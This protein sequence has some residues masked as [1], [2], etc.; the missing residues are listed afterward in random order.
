MALGTA[1]FFTSA[2]RFIAA[3]GMSLAML[4]LFDF[5]EFLAKG[6]VFGFQVL[7]FPLQPSDL[8]IAFA[9]AAARGSGPSHE[10]PVY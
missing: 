8:R 2:L 10:P 4:L 6:L 5:A 1:R 9:T 3:K 7:D